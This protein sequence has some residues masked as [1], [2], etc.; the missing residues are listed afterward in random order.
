VYINKF[1]KAN[2]GVTLADFNTQFRD[3]LNKLDIKPAEIIV[4]KQSATPT[5][6]ATGTTSASTILSPSGEPFPKTA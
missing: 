2:A 5:T 3:I 6:A 4:P 1:F